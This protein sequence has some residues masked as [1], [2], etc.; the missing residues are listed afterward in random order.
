MFR[1]QFLCYLVM[2]V[3]LSAPTFGQSC[4]EI[5]DNSLRLEGYDREATP[6]PPPKPALKM[7]TKA[8]LIGEDACALVAAYAASPG[9]NWARDWREKVKL[10]E[11]AAKD[12]C[13]DTGVFLKGR[14]SHKQPKLVLE[15]KGE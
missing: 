8:E 3:A 11:H 5:S 13:I 9:P 12:T 2:L 10:C 7:P 15:C 14:G 6:P 4:R 1:L